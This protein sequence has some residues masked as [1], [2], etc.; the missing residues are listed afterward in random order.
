MFLD[1]NIIGQP[2]YA[3][4]LF[5]ALKPLKIK[6]VGQASVSILVNDKGLM[7]LAAESGCKA[8]FIGIESVSEAQLQTMHKA[9]K[10]ISLLESALK[11]I[12]K[13]G[14][15]IHASMIFGFDNDTKEIFDET[16]D[17]LIKNKVSTASFN[18]LT[19]YPGT[20]TFEDLKNANRLITTDWR[21][22]DH[23]T[24]VF[25]PQGFTPYQL[26][27]HKN[28]A[29]RNFYSVISV[30]KR[31]LGNLYSPF[32][33]LVMN[34]GHMKQ[35]KVEAQRIMVLKQELFDINREFRSTSLCK[36]VPLSVTQ[37]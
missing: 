34:L 28:E 18:T 15:L 16:V 33:Y 30:M 26:Q 14:I 20:T 3:R 35:V 31:L 27:V 19:P 12:R 2:K 32:M 13:M 6:W 10:E 1:D 21:Y 9:I 5:A 4:E 17:F 36:D 29:K 22:Y 25:K 7:K 11:K 24:V 37:S 23:N 8:L